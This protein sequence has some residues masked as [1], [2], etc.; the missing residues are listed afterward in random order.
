MDC[1][2]FNLQQ[3]CQSFLLSFRCRLL[4]IRPRTKH[5]CH[6]KPDPSGDPVPLNL[7]PLSWWALCVSCADSC[8]TTEWRA[9]LMRTRCTWTAT[10]SSIRRAR[11][12]SSAPTRSSTPR[13]A[14]PTGSWWTRARC[15]RIPTSP[16][17]RTTAS[18]S[19]VFSGKR[20]IL[21][22]LVYV[23]FE[24]VSGKIWISFHF[25]A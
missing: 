9:S 12:P 7:N 19:G 6:Q 1:A 5:T 22:R 20:H 10:L 15:R 17:R 2:E 18:T 13:R 24:C 21:Q 14:S 4:R 8:G 23:R 25:R 16:T 11:P 3:G